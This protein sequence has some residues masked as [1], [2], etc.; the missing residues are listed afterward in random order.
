MRN[1]VIIFFV[2]FAIFILINIAF[3][4]NLKNLPYANYYILLLAINIDLL[5]LIIITAVILR[6]LIKVY[7][8]TKKNILRRKLAN[9]L[10]LYIFIPILI[11]NL[12]SIVVILQST[13]E[14]L[15]SKTRALSSYAEKVYKNLYNSELE[16]LNVYKEVISVLLLEGKEDAV[17]NLTGV[18]SL[19]ITSSCDYEVAEGENEYRLCMNVNGKFYEVSLKKNTELIRNLSDF[20]ALALDLRAFV[21]TRDIIS[22]IFIFFIVFIS[23]ITLLAT[24]WIGMLIARHISEPIERLSAS[25]M[26]IARGNFDIDVTEE[27]TGD[28]IENLSKAFKKMKEN[29][30]VMY[31][32]LK[33]ERDLLEK[34]LDALPVGVMFISGRNGKRVNR[35]LREMFG[36]DKEPE[37]ILRLAESRNNIRIE[38]VKVQDGE[39]YILEDITPIAIAERFKTWQEAVKRIAHEIKNPLTPIRLNLER[40][41]R[42]ADKR[43]IDEEKLKEIVSLILKEIDRISNLI[44]QFKHLSPSGRVNVQ[45]LSLKEFIEDIKRIYIST[46]INIEVNGDKKVRSD[47]SRLKEMFYNLINNSIENGA[48]NIVI[49]IDKDKMEYL[50]D[51]KGIPE[52]ELENIFLPYY[53]NNPKGMGLG[54]AIVKHIAEENGWKIRALPSEKGARFVIYF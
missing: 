13:K 27:R 53:S 18:N 38:K 47:P 26:K 35:T 20:G 40:L 12:I 31:E 17:R 11:L 48:R 49:R 19:I 28:E 2:L 29:L 41:K 14:Y 4:N 43:S 36:E 37:E 44:N 52:S 45:E 33:R 9:I 39:V 34:L 5:A 6:K 24:V 32:D 7:L 21:K 16:K 8:G 46:G 50:D 54:M 25:A 3:I 10:F 22:G 30:K 15:S 42:Y 1:K 23:L 51:G